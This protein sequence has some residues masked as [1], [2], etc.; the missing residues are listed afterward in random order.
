MYKYYNPNPYGKA[1]GDC[2]V[3]ALTIL[4]DDD[5]H[6]VYADLTMQG[7]FMGDMPSSNVVW[8]EYLKENGFRQF[9]LQDMC[10][11]CYTIRDFCMDFPIGKYLVATG[12]HVVAVVDGNY[13]DTS[14]SGNEVP[15][16]YWRKS[17]KERW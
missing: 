17:R 16:Y 5:W 9:P 7:S 4:L 10:P 11:A 15:L 2:V 13:Y 1:V 6:N 14:D 8:G 12:S 3:R